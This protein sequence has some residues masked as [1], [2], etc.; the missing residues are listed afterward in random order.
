MSE[1]LLDW[2]SRHTYRARA[3]VV[4]DGAGCP[5]R[6]WRPPFKNTLYDDI[7]RVVEQDEESRLSRPGDES[8]RY[9][10]HA[11]AAGG[12]LNVHKY[13]MVYSRGPSTLPSPP[14]TGPVN[15]R[16]FFLDEE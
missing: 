8:T 16:R 12:G 11:Y 2:L 9:A 15:R 5:L 4:L 3:L 14:E 10:V 1:R 7:I 6:W 13:S